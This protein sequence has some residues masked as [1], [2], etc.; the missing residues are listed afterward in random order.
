MAYGGPDRIE[1]V[2]PYLQDIRAGRPTPEAVFK[3]VRQRYELIGGR[4]PILERTRAQAEALQAALVELGG[5]PCRTF[6]GMKHWHPFIPEAVSQIEQAGIQKLVGL[7]MAPHYS[8]MSIE[9]YFDRLRQ[10]LD[11]RVVAMELALINSWKDDPGYLD[12][13]EGRIQAGLARFPAGA[14]ASVTLIFTAHS[15]PTRILEWADPYPDELQ[16]TVEALRARFPAQPAYFAYQSAAFTAEPWLGP[17]AG[18]LM[19]SLIERQES[20]LFLVVPIGFVSE[21]VEILFDVDLHFRGRVEA[22]G[23]RLERV[24]M[25]NADPRMMSS[26]ARLVIKSIQERNWN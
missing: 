9:G 7:V 4:S 2:R 22:S 17:D 21:H 26:L 19:L 18:D 12:T 1:E 16:V 20:N 13:L 6:V 14:Q 10:A 11:A 8:R 23:G 5:L 24:E 15:L 3:E 25:P